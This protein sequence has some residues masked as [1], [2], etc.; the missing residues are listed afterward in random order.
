MILYCLCLTLAGS[1]VV[2]PHCE[3]FESCSPINARLDRESAYRPMSGTTDDA[4]SLPLSSGGFSTELSG[5]MRSTN[6]TVHGRRRWSHEENCELMRC[7][8]HARV[9]GRGYQKRFKDLWDIRNPDKSFRTMNNLCCQARNVIHSHLL[10][11]AELKDLQQYPLQQLDASVSVVLL[12]TNDSGDELAPPP[13]EINN[14][15]AHD[16]ELLTLESD[17]VEVLTHQ[18]QSPVGESVS[19]SQTNE[20]DNNSDN[21]EFLLLCVNQCLS[22]GDVTLELKTVFSQLCVCLSEVGTL[23]LDVRQALPRV[24]ET[25]AVRHWL[26]LINDCIH[27]ILHCATLTLTQ[28]DCLVYAGAMAVVRLSGLN[29]K[30][31]NGHCNKNGWRSRLESK[32]QEMRG[33]LSQL[34]AIQRSTTLSAHL[35]R[36]KSRLFRIYHINNQSSFL[37]AIETLKQRI[38]ALSTRLRKYRERLLRYWQNRTFCS[39]QRVFYRHLC[40]D[41]SDYTGA[42]ENHQML[43]FWRNLFEK[44]SDANLSCLWLSQLRERF[45]Q[46]FDDDITDPVIGYDLFMSTLRRLRN[47]ASPGPDGI[48][49]YWWKRMT[50]THDF[51]CLHFHQFLKG[52]IPI[53]PWFPRGR[54]LL[55][56]KCK[57]L[58]APQNYRPITCLNIIYK[59]WTGCLTT[60]MFAHCEQYQLIHP[61]QKGCSRGQYGCIDHLLLTNSVWH[62]VHSKYR[63][64]SV[65][66]LDYRK[67]YDSVP[68]N[69]LLECLRLFRFPSVLIDCIEHLVPLWGTSLFLCLPDRE[70]VK[71]S[72]VSV[73]CGIYQ[74]D[75]LSPLLFCL[76]LNPLS[77]MLD[78]LKGYKVS[79]WEI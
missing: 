69:W 11:E 27:R 15:V 41:A 1:V 24:V 2:D 55:L 3:V 25:S 46:K 43:L 39:N 30:P 77:Y 44:K 79:Q 36:V 40:Q 38:V 74:G 22:N 14:S 13:Q 37:I 76:C 26:A 5:A 21:F 56:P 59:L 42:P 8:Y 57:D 29:I 64:L 54:T 10:T 33:H 60:L 18:D 34:V 35:Q 68:H 75:S 72:N 50:S 32:I 45:S 67:A 28:C 63:S 71:L 65:A 7:Y 48:Q 62:Q 6:I 52:D 66:W 16:S 70:P 31:R 61:A 53:S 23:E 9:A 19:P 49:G 17:R 78:G 20:L 12:A 73:K 4:D 47:W 58:S 51:L